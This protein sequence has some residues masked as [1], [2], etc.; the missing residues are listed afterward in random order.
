M[1][2]E[3]PTDPVFIA[4][5]TFL[6]GWVLATFYSSLRQ[7]FRVKKRDPRDD[8]IRELE[9]EIRIGS[10]ERE[11]LAGSI[12]RLEEELQES[13][14]S[15]ETRDNVISQQQSK[16]DQMHTDLKDSV[17]KTRELRSELTER[18]AENVQAEVKLRE[19]ETELSVAHASTDMISTGVLEYSDHAAAIETAEAEQP[20]VAGKKASEIPS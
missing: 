9:A 19:V 6:L 10:S 5:V 16:L 17:I 18:A 8:R 11:K 4:A 13:Q 1:F 3:I 15:A 7:R 12:K 14:A 2:T 20:S